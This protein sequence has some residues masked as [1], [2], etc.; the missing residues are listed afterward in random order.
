MNAEVEKARNVFDCFDAKALRLLNDEWFYLDDM[1]H[2][3]HA[4]AFNRAFK[5]YQACY[6]GSPRLPRPDAR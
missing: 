6:P 1:Y 4:E 2:V 3:D 5:R